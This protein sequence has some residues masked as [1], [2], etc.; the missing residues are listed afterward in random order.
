MRIALVTCF[1]G[2]LPWYFDYFALSCKFNP[3]VDFFIITDDV[4]YKKELPPNVRLIYKTIA[5]MRQLASQKLGYNALISHGYKM[6]D[7]K[8]TYGYLFADLLKEYDFWG[9]TDIDIIFGN[10][11]DFMTDELLTEFD[12]VCVSNTWVTGCFTLYKNIPKMNN[13]FFQ[14]K[15]H[16]KVFGTEKYQGFDEASLAF[17]EFARG[18]PY[19]EI[20]T[21]IESMTHVVKK[22]EAQGYIKPL[23]DLFIIEG[24]PGKLVWEKGIMTFDN[25][26]EVLSYHL[27]RFKGLPY[28][29][30]FHKPAPDII[31]ISSS[32]F[33]HKRIVRPI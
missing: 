16:R 19:N 15:D 12:M 25:K 31:T 20:K 14:S 10:I 30:S 8:P 9:H 33:Y 32:R 3:D 17:A 2:K 24:M 28:K 27:I 7:F 5:D 13:L 1:F 21:E 22:M 26:F 23:F 18:K 11:R 4:G 6:C 29:K